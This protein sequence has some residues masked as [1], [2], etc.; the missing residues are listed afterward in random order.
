MKLSTIVLL[1]EKNL[2]F[3]GINLPLGEKAL[4]LKENSL[5]L[6][7]SFSLGVVNLPYG[8]VGLSA[9]ISLGGTNLSPR[10][11]ILPFGE[12]FLSLENWLYCFV[13]CCIPFIEFLLDGG[14][15]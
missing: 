9:A 13:P 5:N 10:E 4:F 12:N 6:P 11:F 7:I 1:E 2:P 15:I 3:G 8:G 14:S